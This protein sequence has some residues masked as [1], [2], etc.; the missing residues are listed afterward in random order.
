MHNRSYTPSRELSLSDSFTRGIS[1]SKTPLF[2]KR[3][4]ED[5]ATPSSAHEVAMRPSSQ[6][7]NSLLSKLRKRQ[8]NQDFKI[9]PDIASK[10]V[11]QYILPMFEADSR[12]FT[13]NMRL[14]SFGICKS[15][16]SEDG[17]KAYKRNKSTDIRNL[18]YVSNTVYSELK[19]S[20]QLSYEIQKLKEELTVIHNRLKDTEQTKEAIQKEYDLLK[21][22]YFRQSSSLEVLNFQYTQLLRSNQKAELARVHLT[23]QVAKYRNLYNEINK[24]REDMINQIHDERAKNDIR[25]YILY[26][27]LTTQTNLTYLTYSVIIPIPCLKWKMKSWGKG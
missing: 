3:K 26:I 5:G 19:L 9:S 6:K 4:L 20:E 24:T 7:S 12:K 22:E 17:S 27:T 18:S 13:T 11:K 14:D 2:R 1:I 8:E 23:A 16:R 21:V 25:Y 10:V 15:F